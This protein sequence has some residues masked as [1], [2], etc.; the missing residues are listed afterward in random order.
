MKG[1]VE[2]CPEGRLTGRWFGKVGDPRRVGRLERVK[3]ILPLSKTLEGSLE[4]N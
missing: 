3:P 2:A 4:R 1:S